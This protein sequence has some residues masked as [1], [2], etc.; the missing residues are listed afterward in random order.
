MQKKKEEKVRNLGK[1]TSFGGWWPILTSA[2]WTPQQCSM[3]ATVAAV[4]RR[5][6]GNVHITCNLGLCEQSISALLSL[7]PSTLLWWELPRF[8]SQGARLFHCT[9]TAVRVWERFP[10]AALGLHVHP[11]PSTVVGGSASR[12]PSTKACVNSG[13]LVLDFGR[14]TDLSYLQGS[15]LLCSFG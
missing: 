12:P 4:V 14:I 9:R 1:Q 5:T 8:Y 13:A 2:W 11:H 7:L 3:P 6:K 15:T 10:Q